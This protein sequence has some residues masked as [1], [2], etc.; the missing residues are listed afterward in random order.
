MAGKKIGVSKRA[1]NEKAQLAKDA[2]NIRN[3]IRQAAY[4]K[5]LD[6]ANTGRHGDQTSD[7]L[8]AE[9]QIKAK[10]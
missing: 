1:A 4:F 8:E 2:N 10:A 3:Q 5:W 9:Q 6:R 7:W